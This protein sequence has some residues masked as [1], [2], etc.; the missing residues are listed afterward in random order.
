M[1]NRP[2]QS[3]SSERLRADRSLPKEQIAEF[4]DDFQSLIHGEEGPRKLI[5]LRVPEKLL[6]AFKEKA[7]RGGIAYQ[8]RIVDLMRE[9]VRG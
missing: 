1:K 5:S 3:F 6:H 7:K 2:V 9:W 4:L 8:T